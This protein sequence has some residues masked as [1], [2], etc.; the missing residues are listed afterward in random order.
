[1]MRRRVAPKQRNEIERRFARL[2][3]VTWQQLRQR[4]PLAIG[5]AAFAAHETAYR[6]M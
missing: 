3:T 2:D 5:D 1:M 6:T 4:T